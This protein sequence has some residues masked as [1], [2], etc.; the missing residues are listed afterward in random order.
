MEHGVAPATGSTIKSTM[1]DDLCPATGRECHNAV[2]ETGGCRK[3]RSKPASKPVVRR[4]P[5]APAPSSDAE[6]NRLEKQIEAAT[7]LQVEVASIFADTLDALEH[8]DATLTNLQQAL[9]VKTSTRLE[10][11]RSAASRMRS[12]LKEH[13]LPTVSAPDASGTETAGKL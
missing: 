2:C 1:T 10:E 3:A 4:P 11:L 5:V 12:F 13:A 9:G 8:A 7:K 6:V